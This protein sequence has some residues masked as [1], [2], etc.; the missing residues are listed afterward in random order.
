MA[1]RAVP[2]AGADAA[3][4]GAVPENYDRFLASLLFQ[5]FAEDLAARLAVRPGLRVLETACGT[6]IL[7]ERL[8]ARLGGTGTVVATDLNE[9]MIA[10]ARRRVPDGAVEWR[11]ADA[12]SLPFPDASFDAVVCQFGLMFFPDKLAGVREALRVL[13]AGGTYLFNVFDTLAHHPTARIT[14]ETAAALIPEDPPRFYLAPVSLADVEAVRRL[15]LD[16]GFADVQ[17]VPVDTVGT[18]PSAE[19]AARGLIRGNPIAAAI[20][21]RRPG[22]VPE[23]EAA[24][25]RRIIAELGDRPVRNPMRANVWSARRP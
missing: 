9:P 17:H 8:V 16:G 20:E 7:T 13:R 10:Q 3:F 23:V 21:Q 18:S 12:T 6:G 22:A 15:L 24:V 11:Q 5:P 14:H 2:P 4:L 19:A 25:A 1:E